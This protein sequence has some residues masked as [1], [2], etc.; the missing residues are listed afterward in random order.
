M[1]LIICFYNVI[2]DH[3]ALKFDLKLEVILKS[4]TSRE[5]TYRKSKPRG[6]GEKG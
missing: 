1:V 2:N 4:N 3:E 6:P 5:H